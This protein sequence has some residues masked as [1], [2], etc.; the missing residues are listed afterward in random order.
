LRLGASAKKRVA[1]ADNGGD[2][3]E[4]VGCGQHHPAIQD[5]PSID[6]L[7][8]DIGNADAIAIE[9]AGAWLLYL[10]PY[11]PD[12]NPIEMA[13]AKLKAALRKA[14]ARSIEA[15][16]NAIAVPLPP[17]PPKSV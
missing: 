11:S 16:L 14:A 10:P 15:L 2:G 6:E 4:H 1:V 13:F 5:A 9:A 17:S 3:I 7:L 12:L 8:A